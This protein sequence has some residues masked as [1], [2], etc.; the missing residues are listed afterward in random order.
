MNKKKQNK[1]IKYRI[2]PTAEQASFFVNSFGQMRKL[3]NLLLGK[4]QEDK[5]EVDG[6]V[7]VEKNTYFS[8]KEEFSYLKTSD[9][10]ARANVRLD[11]EQALKN[12]FKNP[13]HFKFPRFKSKKFD[14]KSYTTNNQRTLSKLSGLETNTIEIIDNKIKLPVV[15]IVKIKNHRKIPE[16]WVIRSATISQSTTGK[17]YVSVLYQFEE[18]IIE[19]S[20][21]KNILALDF[22][23]SNF[24]VDQEGNSPNQEFLKP[25]DRFK[26]ILKKEQKKLSRRAEIARKKG[27]KLE[28][29]KNYQK[30]KLVVARVHEKIANIRKDFLHKESNSIAKNYDLVVIE[31]LN[32]A[33][34]SSKKHVYKFGRSI[35]DLGWSF[36]TT[37]LDYKTRDNGGKLIN[38][39]KYFASSKTCSCCGKIKENLKLS[40]RIYSCGSCDLV[41]DRDQNAAIN[42]KKEGLRL[43]NLELNSKTVGTTGLA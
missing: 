23:M 34:M 1:A 39:D 15:G 43:L 26:T 4:W 37:L 20:E 31:D 12:A 35:S 24:Y 9:S 10:L 11:L 27:I 5:K 32:V 14:K 19:K 22:S 33:K 7:A 29:A 42:I 40:E 8:N 16:N 2:Y 6:F 36:F 41:I 17:Y 28:N 38:V 3:Y 21:F 13:A 25:Y 30:Q 18:Y